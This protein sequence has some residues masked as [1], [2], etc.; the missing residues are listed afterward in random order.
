M[1]PKV[2]VSGVI[3][4]IYVVGIE[5]AIAGRTIKSSDA[6]GV[7]IVCIVGIDILLIVVIVGDISI[8]LIGSIAG[9]FGEVF[10]FE[11]DVELV[12]K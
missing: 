9:G 1:S 2:R 10:L 11:R 12:S 5:I 8:T 3:I 4:L 7:A 6:R